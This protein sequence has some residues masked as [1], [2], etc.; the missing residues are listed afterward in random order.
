MQ[1]S[2][3]K[4]KLE[5]KS[6]GFVPTMGYLHSGHLSLVKRS[7]AVADVTVVSIFVNPTQF[8]PN[9]DFNSYPR[10]LKSDINILKRNNVD[11]LFTPKAE[12]IY[13]E[14]FQSFVEVTGI[15]KLLEGEFR[16]TH[17]RGVATIVAI[18]FNCVQPDFA[19]FG[20][21]DAQQAEIIK[22]MV[23]DLKFNIKI[24]VAPIIREKDGLAKS[25]RNVY[26]TN[27]E[28]Q[29]ALVLYKSLQLAKKLIK[30]GQQNAEEIYMAMKK[31][32]NSVQSSKLDYICIVEKDSFSPV[33]F[34][35]ENKEYYILV[36]CKIG[37]TRL[38]DNIKIKSGK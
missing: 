3:K 30:E 34:L 17:F 19:F 37:K 38:I 21:K 16:P 33:E 13:S 14:N 25:S 29:D 32:I 28:R 5:G 35:E 24:I 9:E 23:K 2:I 11:I 7:Q 27:K 31:I 18:L 26:L 1:N 6:I 15:S 36:A 4:L 8:A 20:Q 22:R 10:D 12:D